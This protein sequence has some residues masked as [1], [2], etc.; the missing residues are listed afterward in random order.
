[1]N[2][3]LKQDKSRLLTLDRGL[4]VLE[5]FLTREGGSHNKTL[6]LDGGGTTKVEHETK[7]VQGRG[8]IDDM[9]TGEESDDQLVGLGTN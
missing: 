2:D 3:L 9:T 1:M 5:Y 8:N 4:E 7:Q 6:S